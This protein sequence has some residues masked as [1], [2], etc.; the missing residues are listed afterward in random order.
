M[1]LDEK[2]GPWLVSPIHG[3]ADGNAQNAVVQIDRTTHEV[4][5]TGL[6]WFLAHFSKFVRPG[7]HRVGASVAGLPDGVEVRA[8]AFRND[9]GTLALELLNA[10]ATDSAVRVR[11][12][13]WAADLTLPAVSIS[14]LTWR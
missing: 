2:G 3:D 11:S 9:D 5:F 1:I 8:L 13:G 10:S 7:A 4:T 6:Y 12:G 14:T